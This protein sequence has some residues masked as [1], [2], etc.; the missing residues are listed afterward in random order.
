ML[1][2]RNLLRRRRR[3]MRSLRRRGQLLPPG[4]HIVLSGGVPHPG[5]RLHHRHRRVQGGSSLLRG[6]LLNMSQAPRVGF[7]S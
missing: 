1:S 6:S 2:Q 3:R 5:T 7:R 4:L